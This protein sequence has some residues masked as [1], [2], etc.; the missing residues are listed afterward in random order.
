MLTSTI[1]YDKGCWEK[2]R[3]CQMGNHW[4]L[5]LVWKRA[6]KNVRDKILLT[7]AFYIDHGANE[8]ATHKGL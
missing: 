8:R 3:A 7:A 1:I 2:V 4:V 5:Q 6:I